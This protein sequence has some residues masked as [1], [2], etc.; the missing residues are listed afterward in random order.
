MQPWRR[1]HTEAADERS[2]DEH[3]L[4][5]AQRIRGRE[6]HTVFICSVAGA[7]QNI[8]NLLQRRNY[9]T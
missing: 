7:L 6:L 8:L 9:E 2:D 5:K 4:N 1:I 3:P